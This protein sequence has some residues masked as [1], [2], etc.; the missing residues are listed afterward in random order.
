[1]PVA[2][3]SDIVDAIVKRGATVQLTL[4]KNKQ[5]DHFIFSYYNIILVQSFQTEILNIFYSPYPL[6]CR[7]SNEIEPSLHTIPTTYSESSSIN[8]CSC[9]FKTKFVSIAADFSRSI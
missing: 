1:M 2:L 5:N 8:Y 7:S 6:L 9:G 3:L 4:L